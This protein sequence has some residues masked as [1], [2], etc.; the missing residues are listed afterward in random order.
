M[1][2]I[3]GPVF[4]G[5]DV[6]QNLTDLAMHSVPSDNGSLRLVN[7]TSDFASLDLFAANSVVV[8]GVTP[9]TASG[10]VGIKNDNYSL[11]VRT[12]G[13]GAALVTSSTSLGKKDFQTVVA[14]SNA[15]TLALAVLSD[16]ESDPSSGNAKVRVFNAA[17]GATTG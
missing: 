9:L 3:S 11:D 16:K 15:G 8:G 1:A 7:A 14:Y 13:S 17:S 12:T 2:G 4:G 6:H 10:F 5:A